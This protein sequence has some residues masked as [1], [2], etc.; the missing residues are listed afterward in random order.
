MANKNSERTNVSIE[1]IREFISEVT[2]VNEAIKKARA[3]LNEALDGDDKLD[4][5][6]DAA[7]AARDALK[8][9]VETHAVYKE[10]TARIDQLKEDKKDLVADAKTNG[11]P[12]KEIDIAIKALKQDISLEDSTEIYTNIADLIE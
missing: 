12:K 3:E 5:L 4:E 1:E 8:S 6:K 9:Y 11:I 2:E 10:Y 7:K